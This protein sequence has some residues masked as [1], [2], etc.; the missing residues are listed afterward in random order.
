M[1]SS[2]LTDLFDKA[3]LEKL[4]PPERTDQFFEALFGDAGEG[5]YDISLAFCRGSAKALEFEF[6]LTSKPGKCLA[7]N[8]TYGLPNVFARHP[9]IDIKGMVST[10]G[11]HLEGK[12]HIDEWYCGETVERT[13]DL[14]V[15][16]LYLK[17]S[18]PQR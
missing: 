7:C 3:Q 18:Q 12:A 13:S 16:P 5:A 17:L 1:T 15:I 9:V 8:L 4:L 6:Q 11:E 2:E 14:H 10:I